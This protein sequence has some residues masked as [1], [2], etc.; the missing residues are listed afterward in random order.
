MKTDYHEKKQARIDRY[1][2]LASKNDNQ[3]ESLYTQSNEMASGIPLGQPILVGHHSEK[4]HRKHLEKIRNKTIKAFEASDKASYYAEK[5]SIAESN[6]SISSDD[7]DAIYKLNKKLTTLLNLQEQ[8]KAMNKIIKSKKLSE[9]EKSKKLV[10]EFKVKESTA[11]ELLVPH[12]GRIGIPSYKLTN[13]NQNIAR[14]KKRIEQLKELESRDTFE[15]TVNG[16]RILF[17]VEGNR[18][19]IFFPSNP[20]GHICDTLGKNGFHWSPSEKAWQRFLS[21]YAFRLAKV[22]VWEFYSNSNEG[23]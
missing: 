13:N 7:P 5:A 12:Y 18:V 21:D 3:S 17:N 16:I 8:M 1:N 4:G 9:E 2:E 14:I 23:A 11:K 6:T 15:E 10:A 19:Q 22:F 20:G